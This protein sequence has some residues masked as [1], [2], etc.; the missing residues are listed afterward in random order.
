MTLDL[1]DQ[2]RIQLGVKPDRPLAWRPLLMRSGLMAT[3]LVA[4]VVT[5]GVLL[6][7]RQAQLQQS[8]RELQPGARASEQL[9][10]QGESQLSLIH[11]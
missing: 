11:I 4:L 6:S 10:L 8:V 3:G 1:L 7:L 9:R 5:A 2:R